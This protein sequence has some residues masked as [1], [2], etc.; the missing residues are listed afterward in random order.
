M[1]FFGFS[2]KILCKEVSVSVL[3][4]GAEQWYSSVELAI[5]VS[6]RALE[7]RRADCGVEPPV[8]V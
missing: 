6:S 4:T 8:T 5:I 1:P 7:N 2:A 3:Y